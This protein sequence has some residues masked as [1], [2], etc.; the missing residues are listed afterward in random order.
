MREPSAYAA[1]GVPALGAARRQRGQEH[2]Q[3]VRIV[4]KRAEPATPEHLARLDDV[5]ALWPRLVALL[6]SVFDGIDEEQRSVHG[7]LGRKH[8]GLREPVFCR[9]RVLDLRERGL[10]VALGGKVPAVGRVCLCDVY[11]PVVDTI[12]VRLRNLGDA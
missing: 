5:E 11:D 7:E 1:T 3:P 8:I 10:C 6:Q 2:V 12:R 4:L 9:L